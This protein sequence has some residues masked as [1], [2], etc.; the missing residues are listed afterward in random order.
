MNVTKTPFWGVLCLVILCLPC[1][2][3]FRVSADLS[4][5]W[6]KSTP[7][8][9]SRSDYAAGALD[10]RP[11]IAGGTYW[12]GSKGHWIKRRYCAST[13]AIDPAT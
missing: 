13:H 5:Q 10:D 12:D 3:N 1:H 6:A 7:F 11:V 2:G 9:E 4:L 8:P